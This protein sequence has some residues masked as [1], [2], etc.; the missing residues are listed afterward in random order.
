[1]GFVGRKLQLQR[2]QDF[3]YNN[4]DTWVMVITGMECVGK[5]TLLQKSQNEY[6]QDIPSFYKDFRF[7][8]DFAGEDYQTVRQC[9]N[10]LEGL[11]HTIAKYC[12]EQKVK[13]F[14][15][16]LE[17]VRTSIVNFNFK[18]DTIIQTLQANNA[19]VSQV[20]MAI[21]KSLDQGLSINIDR[22]KTS[23][24]HLLRTFKQDQL[25]ILLDNFEWLN[26]YDKLYTSKI[27][28][29]DQWVINTLL[30]EIYEYLKPHRLLVI[31]TCRVK[32]NLEV[33]KQ[34]YVDYI[35][36][37][38]LFDQSEVEDYLVQE[39]ISTN[40]LKYICDLTRGHPFCLY[41]F[42]KVFKERQQGI[43]YDDDNFLERIEERIPI[44]FYDEAWREFI[45]KRVL[46]HLP[47][48]LRDLLRYGSIAEAFSLPLLRFVFEDLFIMHNR[49]DHEIR[50]DFD[51]F[52]QYP[53][54]IRLEQRRDDQQTH[55]IHALL[56]SVICKYLEKQELDRLKSYEK[57]LE[58]YY[59]LSCETSIMA[60]RTTADI[61]ELALQTGM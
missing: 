16:L 46:E 15:E 6:L 19:D 18:P 35:L 44:A 24:R 8:K 2:I 29:T 31:I 26:R 37:L 53:C 21:Q 13:D 50:D 12:D 45:S 60:S 59:N 32:P 17:D 43:I 39:G 20:N 47:R 9:I 25:V 4:K 27:Q 48:H 51:A 56:R 36:N 22:L 42:C 30:P 54:I 5:S 7:Y 1:M 34:N 52:V 58:E 28:S 23:L 11:V 33:I 10:I 14:E 40:R 3:L 55:T 61:S 57:R 41:L 49:K 38:H